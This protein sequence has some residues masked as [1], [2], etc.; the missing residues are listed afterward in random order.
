MNSEKFHAAGGVPEIS[1]LTNEQLEQLRNNITKELGR[2]TIEAMKLLINDMEAKSDAEYEKLV[3]KA[4]VGDAEAQ[5]ELSDYQRAKAEIAKADAVEDATAEPVEAAEPAAE[6]E[7]AAE[8]EPAAEAPA[9]EGEADDLQQG[10]D[11]LPDEMLDQVVAE[12]DAEHKVGEDAGEDAGG[13]AGE[14]KEAENKE[15][16]TF[17]NWASEEIDEGMN[18]EDFNGVPIAKFEEDDG[19]IKDEIQRGIEKLAREGVVTGQAEAEAEEA[20]TEE[21]VDAEVKELIGQKVDE[22]IEQLKEGE[23]AKAEAKLEEDF[24]QEA[25]KDKK[26]GN[27]MLKFFQKHPKLAKV[28]VVAIMAIAGLGGI[29]AMFGSNTNPNKQNT[30]IEQNGDELVARA[31]AKAGEAATGAGARLEDEAG[32]VEQEDNEA[33][34]VSST[35]KFSIDDKEFTY[36]NMKHEGGYDKK[37]D[38]YY[39]DDKDGQHSMMGPAYEGEWKGT[40]SA[41]ESYE[42]LM[43]AMKGS[44]EMA[45]MI[46]MTAGIP[47][48][49]NIHSQSALNDFADELRNKSPED[50][51]KFMTAASDYINNFVNDGQMVVSVINAG[52]HYQST[53]SYGFDGNLEIGVDK[54]V[55]HSFDVQMVDFLDADGNSMF[56]S[57]DAKS[58]IR[59]MFGLPSK[60]D[61]KAGWSARCGQIVVQMNVTPPAPQEKVTTPEPEKTPKPTP[62][63]S[64]TPKPTPETPTPTPETPTPTPETPTPTPETGTP[65]P[66]PETPTPTPEVTPTPTPETPTPTPSETPTPTP[67][68]ETLAPKGP[69]TH[70][71]PNQQPMGP[72]EINNNDTKVTAEERGNVNPNVNPGAAVPGEE[73]PNVNTETVNPGGLAQTETTP[74]PDLS[75]PDSRTENIE[76]GGSASDL[77]D[78]MRQAEQAQ[79]QAG[80]GQNAGQAGGNQ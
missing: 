19:G 56:N 61:F 65:T 6:V 74:A 53:Y 62:E 21:L 11:N 30:K 48:A 5:K 57:D 4:N 25:K 43:A 64:E 67:P 33:E 44:P 36:E 69:D 18:P 10:I 77:L 17:D 46:A 45:S 70:A 75:N 72:T 20:E 59:E 78:R 37:M 40:E 68:Q 32:A 35:A 63:P 8:V 9:A 55:R 26:R 41:F 50:F 76:H 22:I 71:G 52:D 80:A 79:R 42:G 3:D 23:V 38:S 7:A 66:T 73:N 51:D 29:T 14:A 60:A 39:D 15:N 16:N 28:A 49:E 54:D 24:E 12:F 1:G 27:K 13:D 2:R 58:R 31:A 47:G 34:K